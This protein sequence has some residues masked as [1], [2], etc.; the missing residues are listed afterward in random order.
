MTRDTWSRLLPQTLLITLRRD[1]WCKATQGVDQ[2]LASG[3]TTRI[4]SA[5]APTVRSKP[6][7]APGHRP[8]STNADIESDAPLVVP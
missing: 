2:F 7:C 8:S 6:C 1:F 5:T 3:L 4:E